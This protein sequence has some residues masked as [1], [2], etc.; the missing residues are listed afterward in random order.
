MKERKMKGNK[1][2]KNKNHDGLFTEEPSHKVTT[3]TYYIPTIY[4]NN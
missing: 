4:A 2:F 3:T 1:D